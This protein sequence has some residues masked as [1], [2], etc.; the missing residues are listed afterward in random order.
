ML[1]TGLMAHSPHIVVA[2]TRRSW[3]REEK[4]AIIAEVRETRT[5]VSAVAR[6]HGLHPSLLFRWRRVG[7][8]GRLLKTLARVTLLIPDAG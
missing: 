4:R 3:S 6:R 8:C 2:S 5:T 1:L 7:R